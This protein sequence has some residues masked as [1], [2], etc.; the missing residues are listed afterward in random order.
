MA[1]SVVIKP[2]GPSTL[3]S[4]GNTQHAGVAVFPTTNEATG[5]AAFWNTSTTVYII[6]GV[7]PLNTS[8][9]VP[10]AQSL[11]IPTDGNNT[12]MESFVLPPNMSFP[13]IVAVPTYGGNGFAVTAIASAA[14]PTAMYVT[15]VAAQ[16]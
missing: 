8:G 6:V 10:T 16:S 7:Y 1:V 14:G 12:G 9:T 13:M 2:A 11:A 5:Y 15:P 3:L 4:V